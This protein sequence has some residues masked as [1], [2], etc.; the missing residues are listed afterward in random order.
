MFLTNEDSAGSHF[1]QQLNELN[2]CFREEI[3]PD[4]C[5][6]R[7]SL[8]PLIQRDQVLIILTNWWEKQEAVVK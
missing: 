8:S 2:A 4:T 7:N 3:F 1:N 5:F 6:L